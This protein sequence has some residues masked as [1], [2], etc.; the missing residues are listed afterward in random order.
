[1]QTR[2]VQRCTADQ[3]RKVGAFMRLP[4]IAQRRRH[5]ARCAIVAD[6]GVAHRRNVDF[7]GQIRR[8]ERTS[9]WAVFITDA[10]IDKGVNRTTTSASG[11]LIRAIRYITDTGA[12]AL[13]RQIDKA[14]LGVDPKRKQIE[15]GIKAFAGFVRN[16]AARNH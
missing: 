14:K 3:A 6:I 5:L 15:R 10:D 9:L 13:A 2:L 7:V 8:I 16:G 1:M 11:R 12:D 4:A